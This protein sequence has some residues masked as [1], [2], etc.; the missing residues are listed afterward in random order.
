M[1]EYEVT[2]KVSLG[3]RTR[4]EMGRN[5]IDSPEDYIERGIA[6]L[7]AYFDITEVVELKK[8]E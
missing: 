8:A 3:T 6:A 1:I 2:I 5:G 7:S 4:F